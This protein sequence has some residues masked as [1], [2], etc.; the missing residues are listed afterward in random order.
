MLS[1]KKRNLILNLTSWPLEIIR[2]VLRRGILWSPSVCAKQI[3]RC[4]FLRAAVIFHRALETRILSIV[5]IVQPKS[6][7]TFISYYVFFFFNYSCWCLL[8]FSFLLFCFSSFAY[9]CFSCC[10]FVCCCYFLLRRILTSCS[11]LPFLLLMLWFAVKCFVVNKY[12]SNSVVVVVV[13]V[14]VDVFRGRE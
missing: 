11:L 10:A 6:E 8:L 2:V 5:F 14:E 12:W 4:N 9:C 3:T 7:E 1:L 13:A